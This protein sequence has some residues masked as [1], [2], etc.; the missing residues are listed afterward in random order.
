MRGNG[1]PRTVQDPR[2][3]KDIPALEHTNDAI[4]Q[5]TLAAICGSDLHLSHGMMPDTR[6]GMTFGMSSL[7]WCTR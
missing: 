7:V 1:L 6:V 3:G 5:V 4:V 2:R